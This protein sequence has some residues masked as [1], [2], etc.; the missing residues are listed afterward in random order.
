MPR[1]TLIISSEEL[2]GHLPGRG[3]LEDYSAA[4]VLLY[5]FWEIARNR[6]PN[7]E[8]LIYLST[9]AAEPWLAS[10]YWEH[11][12]ASNMTMDFDAFRDR[13]AGAASLDDMVSEIAARVPTPV[14]H[15]ALETCK[16]LPLGPAS[17]LLDLCDLPLA[18]RAGL[19]AVP[20]TNRRFGPEVLSALLQVNRTHK[21][22]DT[23]NAAKAQILAQA[24]DS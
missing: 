4:P 21:D 24:H 1:R 14:H 13:Y 2:A 3:D 12:K 11:V 15:C 10:A 18:L 6:F 23:R 5:A 9:R 17:P 20:A 22:A 8:I 7:A 19:E 16:D